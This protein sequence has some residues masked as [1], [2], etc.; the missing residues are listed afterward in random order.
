MFGRMKDMAQQIQMMQKMMADPNFK[1][2]ISHPK[3]QELF[4]DPAF[5][6]IAQQRDFQKI[7]AYPP[8]AAL[9]R[10]PEV[11]VLMAK[12]DP[13]SLFGNG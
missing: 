9:M 10:D 1:A 13:K 5:K 12:I 7:A 2:F 6:Q 4:R 11:G 8:F 3:V